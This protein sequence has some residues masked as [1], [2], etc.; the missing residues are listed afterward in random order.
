M[1]TR[2][3]VND[4]LARRRIAMVGVSRSAKDFTRAVF[5]EFQARGYDAVPVN[6]QL[7]EVEGRPCYAS[8]GDIQ[9]PVEG[10]LVMT[11]PAVSG[12]VVRECGEA[13]IPRVWMVRGAE[14]RDAVECAGERGMEVIAGQCPFMFLPDS[15]WFH[16][17][18]GWLLQIAGKYPA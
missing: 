14:S 17:A 12:E 4:F 8:V 6:P 10:A 2:A 18:H 13:G 1:N 5:R 7:K 3:E 15:A 11:P 16:R 9:P